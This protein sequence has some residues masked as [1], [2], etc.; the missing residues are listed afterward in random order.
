LTPHDPEGEVTSN[1]LGS[2]T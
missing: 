1:F 2:T